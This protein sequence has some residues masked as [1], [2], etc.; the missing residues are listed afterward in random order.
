[1][2]LGF[3]FQDIASN[4]IAGITLAFQK[5]FNV[6]D[7]VEVNDIF[8]TVMRIDL[9]TTTVRTLNGQMVSIPNKDVFLNAVTD[10]SQL[11][12]RR[13]ELVVG[14]SYGEDLE[15]V[16]DVSLKAI[17]DLKISLDKEPID[18]YFEEFSDSSI[19]FVLRFWTEFKKQPDYLEARS[20]AI[21][22]IK[23][24]FDREGIVIP[25]PITTLDFNAK[26]GKELKAQLKK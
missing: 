20:Q 15:K 1:M 2:A 16:K 6:G 21:I 9:R 8:G 10:Y 19:N 22:A 18:L 25:F 26:G 17:K 24:A 3:A 12:R 14:V 13:I 11:G 4:F 5:Q 7:L 23:Q